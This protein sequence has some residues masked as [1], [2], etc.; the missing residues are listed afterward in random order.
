VNGAECEP[1]LHKDKELLR[2]EAA[3]MLA[4]LG[5]SWTRRRTRGRDG[6]KHK[7]ED[8]IAVPAGFSSPGVRLVPSP[9]PTAG[10]EFILVHDVTGRVISRR[11]SPA[12]WAR[13]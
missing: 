4:G 9:T 5:W 1:L 11:Y 13:W 6:V 2:H 3:S 8:V 10:D 12:T 7:Y